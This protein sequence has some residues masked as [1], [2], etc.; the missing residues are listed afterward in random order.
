MWKF[1]KLTVDT[2]LEFLT[3]KSCTFL[4]FCCLKVLKFCFSE[5]WYLIEGISPGRQYWRERNQKYLEPLCPAQPFQTFEPSISNLAIFSSWN[6]IRE[7]STISE[8]TQQHWKLLEIRKPWI[9]VECSLSNIYWATFHQ[10][11][12]PFNFPLIG[13]FPGKVLACSNFARAPTCTF[14]DKVGL[15]WWISQPKY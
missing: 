10:L 7:T 8:L 3:K 14:V 15:R 5:P 1:R 13:L 12:A 9:C 11:C 4:T 2:L 6:E